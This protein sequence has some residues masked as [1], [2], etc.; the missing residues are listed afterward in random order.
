MDKVHKPSDSECRTQSSEPFRFQLATFLSSHNVGNRQIFRNVCCYAQDYTTQLSKN[1][2]LHLS[3]RRDIL[4]HVL[5]SSGLENRDYVRKGSTALTMRHPSIRQILALT[6]QTSGGSSVGIVRS[7]TSSHKVSLVSQSP[8]TPETK[9]DCAG[10][11][12][13]NFTMPIDIE[14]ERW[15]FTKNVTV[16]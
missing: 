1:Y 10:E 6:S 2:W 16:I 3:Q 8:S 11:Y 5:S 12:Q 4:T 15:R 9:I 13:Q 7:R 14:K